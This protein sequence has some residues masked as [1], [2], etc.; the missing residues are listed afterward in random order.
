MLTLKHNK[1][2]ENILN[3]RVPSGRDANKKASITKGELVT[4]KI[5]YR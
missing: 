1:P 4:Y 2:N 3:M 5:I